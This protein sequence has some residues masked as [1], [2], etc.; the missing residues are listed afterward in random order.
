MGI[1]AQWSIF[2]A[3]SKHLV[4]PYFQ[5]EKQQLVG[6]PTIV[7]NKQSQWIFKMHI[8]MGLWTYQFTSTPVSWSTSRCSN[9]HAP[10]LLNSFTHLS[11]WLA[12]LGRFCFPDRSPCTASCQ[13]AAI[14]RMG[15]KLKKS[16]LNPA[17]DFIGIH[18]LT[19]ELIVAPLLKMQIKVQT[20][21]QHHR[22]ARW[23]LP[24]TSTDFIVYYSL[25][26]LWFLEAGSTSA[27]SSSGHSRNGTKPVGFQYPTIFCTTTLLLV[28]P[29]RWAGHLSP[30]PRDKGYPVY[31]H[32]PVRLG[33]TAGRV[34]FV[35]SVVFCSTLPT[36]QPSQDG[37]SNF[38]PRGDSRHI[39]IAEWWSAWCTT[40]PQ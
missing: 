22:L 23:C 17:Q 18:F 26:P 2:F 8:F 36:C 30:D 11:G 37:G 25:W 33:Y 29:G 31:R 38:V 14:L 12:H 10:T 32:L 24:E 1:C 20:T 21:L 27:S 13:S 6:L 4:V 40:T 3:F 16:E 5:M 7:I 28:S 19:Q 34:R 15:H 9:S 39:F 35:W